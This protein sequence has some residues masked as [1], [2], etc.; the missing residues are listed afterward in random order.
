MKPSPDL[1]AKII[2]CVVRSVMIAALIAILGGCVV[3][4]QATGF[5]YDHLKIILSLINAYFVELIWLTMYGA[6][7]VVLYRATLS[8]N[9]FNFVNFFVTKPGRHEDIFKFGYFV[10]LVTCILILFTLAWRD[11]ITEGIVGVIL[12]AF[13]LKNI[14][15]VGGKI[16]G[17]P[18]EQSPEEPKP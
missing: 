7:G 18:K 16:W 13:I 3:L 14:A 8:D 2:M 4:I 12:G 6:M 15:D 10:L 17:K 5:T 11:K 9:E 1:R